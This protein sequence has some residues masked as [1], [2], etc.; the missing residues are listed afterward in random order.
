MVENQVFVIGGFGPAQTKVLMIDTL[1]S[2]M[3]YKSQIRNGRYAHS[4][5]RITGLNGANQILVAG[6]FNGYNY[7]KSTEIYSIDDNLW[8]P[9]TY[10]RD[11]IK[12]ICSCMVLHK[13]FRLKLGPDLLDFC[14]Y[15]SMLTSSDGVILLGCQF[16]EEVI[17]QMKPNSEGNFV[18]NKMNQTL[19]YPRISTIVDYIDDDQVTCSFV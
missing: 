11:F 1:T 7:L 6:G 14:A 5:A 8:K 16:N 3:T 2:A 17:Y 10:I 19:K 18:W 15:G 13:C 4:C 12:F 9:G